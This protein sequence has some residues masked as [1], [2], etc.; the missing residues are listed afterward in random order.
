MKRDFISIADWSNT[1]LGEILDLSTHIKEYPANFSNALK[2]KH[3]A[4]IFEKPSLRTHVTFDI[5]IS[6]LGAHSIYLDQQGVHLGKRESLFD[7]A[8][9]LER[10]V[11]AVVI[12]T[13]SHQTCVDLSR[14]MLKPVINA[15]DDQEHPCQA[16]GDFL[17]VREKVGGFRGKKMVFVG[18][19]NNV[20]HSLMLFA[21]AVGMDFIASTPR[22]YEPNQEIFRRASHTAKKSGCTVDIVHNPKE[23]VRHADVVYTDVWTSMGQESERDERLERFKPYQ[24]N[25]KLMALAKHSAVF[26]HCLPAHRGEE[27]TNEVADSPRSVIFDQ[28]EN[29]LHSQ[30]AILL[31]LLQA[32]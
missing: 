6:Q 31:R 22:G 20:C 26:M 18:D 9:N 21:G 17:T 32:D 8:R 16:V 14:I 4:L 30:K 11:D 24:V 15:L 12:R 5:G 3:L 28:A 23:A 19:G 10:W 27:V 1:D 2:G 13:F 29:R 7:V 25:A